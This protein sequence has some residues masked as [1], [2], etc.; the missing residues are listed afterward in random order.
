MLEMPTSVDT[1]CA[2]ARRAALLQRHASD[3]RCSIVRWT[4]VLALLVVAVVHSADARA[5]T[6][7]P[8]EIIANSQANAPA[9]SEFGA[10]LGSGGDA[11]VAWSIGGV[12]QV[13]VRPASSYWGYQHQY[14]FPQAQS[15]DVGIDAAGV[16]YVAYSEAVTDGVRVALTSLGASGWLAPVE[17]APPGAG[18]LNVRLVVA[19]DGSLMVIWVRQTGPGTNDLDYAQR[20]LDGSWT[21]GGIS[22]IGTAPWFLSARPSGAVA[23]AWTQPNTGG[24]FASVGSTQDVNSFLPEPVAQ[25]GT[26]RGIQLAPDGSAV[27][28]ASD[29]SVALW[30]SVRDRSTHVWQAKHTLIAATTP[31]VEDVG[32]AAGP[33][34]SLWIAV[35]R[36]TTATG[37]N[38][39]QAFDVTSDGVWHGPELIANAAVGIDNGYHSPQLAVLPDDTVMA[40]Y[41]ENTD[42]V[43]RMRDPSGAW[44]LPFALILAHAT[45]GTDFVV[46]KTL[47]TSA[48]GD[49]LLVATGDQCSSSCLGF[50]VPYDNAPPR[51]TTV[52]PDT[53][54]QGTPVAMSATVA[55]AFSP[56]AG[57]TSWI[58]DDGASAAGDS[59]AHT[60]A[61]AGVHTVTV[62]RADAL[63]HTVT[64]ARAVSIALA[65]VLCPG[66]TQVPGGTICPPPAVKDLTARPV[67]TWRVSQVHGLVKVS[68][69][70]GAGKLA[71]SVLLLRPDGS[72][73]RSEKFTAR[74][75]VKL[76]LP[77][78]LFAN[79]GRW[80]IR[81]VAKDTL[82]RKASARRTFALGRPPEGVVREV[83]V[84]TNP[85]RPAT[86]TVDGTLRRVYAR[87]VFAARPK[88][89]HDVRV[90]WF[91]GK[92]VVWRSKKQSRR[93][94]TASIWTSPGDPPLPAG[95]WHCEIRAGGRLAKSITFNVVT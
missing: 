95:V 32:T 19:D 59:V 55:D 71:G 34:N 77:L 40:A 49:S 20:G 36:F 53:G 5:G 21:R 16:T 78:P 12:P 70:L 13:D 7:L 44:T 92:R 79:P 39:L 74:A 4:A 93:V 3:S 43:M 65:P 18:I 38:D 9:F 69:K 27:V 52:I 89:G 64:V 25:A 94:V 29:G 14:N 54:V 62:S 50:V 37:A 45:F 10:A 24:L 81:I 47:L 46:A 17:V 15:L 26:L 60:F 80:S 33:D 6:W 35:W 87:F 83:A 42:V 85:R 91:Y 11:A 73:A 76:S 30:A 31:T 1:E 82:G 88:A 68:A 61:T 90:T 22:N 48:S 8:P 63:G 51:M 66:G 72:T 84:F 41:R 28:V 57:S 2:R 86:L 67:A 75:S 58:F 23:M 56:L